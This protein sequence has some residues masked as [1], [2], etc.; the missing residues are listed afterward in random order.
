MELIDVVRDWVAAAA[1]RQQQIPFGE[2]ATDEANFMV[3]WFGY[4]H[5]TGD[6]LVPETAEALFGSF[7]KWVQTEAHLGYYATQEAHHGTEPFIF[8]PTRLYQL[9]R[10][11]DHIAAVLRQVADHCGNWSEGVPD[12]Y[13]WDR[14]VFRSYFLGT[15]TVRPEDAPANNT[16][17]FRFIQIA[18]AA[19]RMT[20]EQRYLDLAH[21][22]VGEWARQI[23]AK[24]RGF[25]VVMPQDLL[26]GE[27]AHLEQA[28]RVQESR[29]VPMQ[30]EWHLAGGG[31]D[32]FLDLHRLSPRDE[33]AEVVERAISTLLAAAKQQ[34]GRPAAA[35]IGKYRDFTGDHSLD[36]TIRRELESGSENLS[37]NIRGVRPPGPKLHPM[38]LGQRHDM[39]IWEY[40]Q[41]DGTW[42][43][44]SGL[45]PAAL[46]LL[47]RL[48]G[49]R[50]HAALA[51]KKATQRMRWAVAN[52]KDGR[53]HADA[54]WCIAAIAGG[55][56]RDYA[57]G[58][59][60]GA[61]FPV[62][63][64]SWNFCGEDLLGVSYSY[65][66]EPGLPPGV[67]A[68]FQ[69]G[70]PPS[71]VLANASD[72]PVEFQ[73]TFADHKGKMVALGAGEEKQVEAD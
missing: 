27:H 33:Y 73:V 36:D 11:T 13:D 48:T 17:H 9:G 57:W 23:L 20:G 53:E 46:V 8:F 52:L 45:S 59:L 60:T 37:E 29:D 44:D 15:K 2:S 55:H 21:D 30:A 25:V 31:F 71:V 19:Y 50:A 34:W 56:G 18:L 72:D 47:Y 14:H 62:A 39:V 6:S 22:Y 49:D 1:E 38:G 42:R 67:A 10:C 61:L 26:H 54:G 4:Y 40:E 5:L 64:G 3:S 66:G 69:A 35:I 12:W 70:Q 43:R 68:L 28:R 51:M 32:T 65:D 24:D 41:E 63:L 16:D 7:H 58:E